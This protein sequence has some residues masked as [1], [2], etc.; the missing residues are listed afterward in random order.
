MGNN[1]GLVYRSDIDGLR[2]IAI[3]AVITFHVFP[4]WLPGG[5]VGVD[6][7]FVIS[8]Y[9]ITSL[10]LKGLDQGNFSFVNFYM[11]RVKRI[12][13]ALILVM[14][15]CY[16]LGWFVLTGIEY[17]RLGHHMVAGAT[18]VSNLLLASEVGYFDDA[19]EKKPLLHLWSLGV[20]E[21]FYIVWPL[22]VWF[23]WKRGINIVSA[24]LFLIVLSFVLTISSENPDV[25]FFLPHTRFWELLVG[26]ILAYLHV[27][28]KQQ[29]TNALIRM[30]F[31]ASRSQSPKQRLAVLN[32]ILAFGGTILVIV[33]LY[34]IDEKMIFP[35]WWA[36]LPTGATFLLIAAGPDALINK[37]I[38]GSNL[39]VNIGLISYPLYLWHWPALFFARLFEGEE[40]PAETV[41]VTLMASFVL[42]WLTYTFVERPIRFGARRKT[43]AAVTVAMMV[44]VGGF[45]LHVQNNGGYIFRHKPLNAVLEAVAD[46]DF[47]QPESKYY[48]VTALFVGN[49]SSRKVAFLG[50]SNMAQYYPRIKHLIE[51]DKEVDLQAL[52]L[53]KMGC[54]PIP[55]VRSKKNGCDTFWD[56]ALRVKED[57]TVE[58]VVLTALWTRY[59]N[60]NFYLRSLGENKPLRPIGESS[61]KAFLMLEKFMRDVTKT[62]KKV[63]LV[64][65]I[66]VGPAFAPKNL[67][68]KGWNRLRWLP[69]VDNPSR[70]TIEAYRDAVAS[71]LKSI[72]ARAGATVIDPLDFLCDTQ[73]C[74]VFIEEGKPMHSDKDHLRASFVRDRLTYLDQTLGV[75][76]APSR[77]K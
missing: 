22:L 46:A 27:F 18:F 19:A 55:E 36:L 64:L 5:F 13:P 31:S 8:G 2:A 65:E 41:A 61:E 69:T 70:E 12:F 52:F 68:Q 49:Q 73:T 16:A 47:P 1:S 60:E 10:I 77:T 34:T 54:P 9:L 21:Q 75:A 63:F 4:G 7:F 74:P 17:A 14:A 48:D 26:G 53:V 37:R 44:I 62:G 38:L 72:A 23:F 67:L 24:I 33:S 30:V 11:R 45:G 56:S 35:G 15:A 57:A 20:E 58:T 76:L 71:R 43:V 32:E 51:T 66:P 50:D 29:F 6:I 25:A 42:A 39:L 28:R 3:L 40:L 59:F